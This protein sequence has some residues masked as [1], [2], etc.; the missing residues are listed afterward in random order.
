MQSSCGSPHL[1]VPLTPSRDQFL[2]SPA[3]TIPQTP[4][5]YGAMVRD[6]EQLQGTHQ[7]TLRQLE[8]AQIELD[9]ARKTIRRNNDT[10]RRLQSQISELEETIQRQKITISNQSKTISDPKSKRPASVPM[11]PLRH[12]SQESPFGNVR[13]Q[14]S[15]FD[16]TPP[17][18]ELPVDAP[19]SGGSMG[20]AAHQQLRLSPAPDGATSF[21]STHSFPHLDYNRISTGFVSRFQELW[22]KSEVFGQ[23]HANLPDVRKDSKVDQRVKN[24]LMVISDTHGAFNLLGTDDTRFHLVAK[25][26]NFYLVREVLKITV[27]KG[28]DSV[29]DSEIGQIKKQL[30][31]DTPV[32]VRNMMHIAT[33]NQVN[34]I[35][36]KAGFSEFIRRR[37]NER[38]EKLWQLIGPLTYEG[39]PN[40]WSDLF[41]IVSE[42]HGLSLDMFSAL[43]EYKLEFPVNNDTFDQTTMVNRDTV[44]KGDPAV[45]MRNGARVRLGITPIIKMRHNSGSSSQIQLI[46]LGNVLLKPAPRPQS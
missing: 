20:S 7:A 40:A 26:I 6:Y 27:V 38:T 39:G 10:I 28:F 18:F 8:Q 9:D 3:P 36:R 25:A 30:F 19:T 21:M 32:T 43:F 17:K 16:Q 4:R 22:R 37:I 31:P 11:T 35:K 45:L 42:A 12:G 2:G 34:N 41:T 15:I 1:P 44:M 46:H 24:Y 14:P 23:V 13:G 29:T 5:Q 33:A